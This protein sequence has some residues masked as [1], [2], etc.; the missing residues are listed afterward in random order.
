MA[1]TEETTEAP[2]T[3]TVNT[4]TTAAAP[5]K[6]GKKG[7]SISK[8][9]KAKKSTPNHPPT[10]VMVTTA[11]TSLKEKGGSSFVAIKKYISSTYKV[12][13]EKLAPF[14]KKFIKNAVTVGELVQTKGK[15]ASG[16]IAKKK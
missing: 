11:I 16:S 12:D 13:S 10:A 1:E 8:A 3:T 6:K 2:A 4:T 15:G 14:I 7:A 5:V 9:T